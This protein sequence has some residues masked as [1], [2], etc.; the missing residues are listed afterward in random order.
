MSGFF[1][2]C[3]FLAHI[4][5]H[6]YVI[7]TGVFSHFYWLPEL[8][9]FV[10]Y[11]IYSKVINIKRFFFFLYI[12]CTREN[13][14]INVKTIQFS[15]SRYTNIRNRNSKRVLYVRLDKSDGNFLVLYLLIII[16][17]GNR[18]GN[19]GLCSS[20]YLL[21]SDICSTGNNCRADVFN[22]R[23]RQDGLID[24]GFRV[25]IDVKKQIYSYK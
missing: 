5:G 19:N 6:I 18:I 22:T 10:L 3:I 17:S 20:S 13:P 15:F 23:V 14:E 25:D 24:I 21:R 7:P 8:F 1:F 11:K 4:H 9:V 12:K 16:H 2:Y